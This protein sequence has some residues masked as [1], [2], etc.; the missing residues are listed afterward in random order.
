[1]YLCVCVLSLKEYMLYYLRVNF[2]FSSLI[3][4]DFS[5]CRSDFHPSTIY[6]KGE[7]K[8]RVN[9]FKRLKIQ[10]MFMDIEGNMRSFV[11]RIPFLVF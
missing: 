1:M 10:Y 11:A 8:T 9:G 4:T 3:L 5:G 7:S 6:E 2:Q